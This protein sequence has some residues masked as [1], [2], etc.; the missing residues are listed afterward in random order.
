MI[1]IKKEI[2]VVYNMGGR[3]KVLLYK[4]NREF[5]EMPHRYDNI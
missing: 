5:L 2:E 3:D 4:A 1:K